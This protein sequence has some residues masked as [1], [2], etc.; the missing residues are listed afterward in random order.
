[1]KSNRLYFLFIQEG[2]NYH[3]EA[4]ANLIASTFL[5]VL[6]VSGSD[7]YK[8]VIFS[9]YSKKTLDSPNIANLVDW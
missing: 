3:F 7:T 4:F 5:N 9:V 6:L 8:K 1:M 2:K